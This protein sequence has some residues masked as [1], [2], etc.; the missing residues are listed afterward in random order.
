MNDE[1]FRARVAALQALMT[2]DSIDALVISNPNSFRYFSDHLPMLSVSPTRTWYLVVPRLG[3]PI[4]CVPS[5]GRDDF[6]TESWITSVRTWKSPQPDDEGRT[7]L[8]ETLRDLGA[9]RVAM[10]FGREM[11]PSMPLR[12][13]DL[14]RAELA[15]VEWIDAAPLIWSVREIK[16]ADELATMRRVITAVGRAFVD[17]APQ[18]RAGMT[19]QEAARL[20][21][22]SVMT[23][24][25]DAVPYLACGSG[26][27]GYLSLTRR[28]SDRVIEDGDVIAFD[29]G[30]TIDGYWCDFDRNF[31]IGTPS[32]ETTRALLAMDAGMRAAQS[33]LAPGASVAAIRTAMEKGVAEAGFAPLSGSGRWGH[34]VGLDLTEPPSISEADDAVLRAG[35]VI[36]FE[37]LI[38]G[39]CRADPRLGLVAEDM[40]VVT[41]SGFEQ[42]T[43]T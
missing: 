35:M 3:E 31:S 15:F 10:E 5:I 30:A 8:A 28:A 18:L 38:V 2:S 20:L 9:T 4:A 6:L 16:D 14:L 25:A 32:G 1:R 12:D 7:A 43:P 27:G 36:T 24:G 26:P 39:H 29:L 42:L 13:L 34:G 17:V 21:T 23:H 22:M 19:E 33:I 41:D 11:R 40:F 37:P